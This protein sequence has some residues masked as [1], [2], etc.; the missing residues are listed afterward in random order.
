M[1]AEKDGFDID[2][3]IANNKPADI[4]NEFS[5]NWQNVTPEVSAQKF[6]S[7][8]LGEVPGESSIKKIHKEFN[9]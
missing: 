5:P 6:L 3:F 9:N 4:L 2:D 1:E 8:V 7:Q